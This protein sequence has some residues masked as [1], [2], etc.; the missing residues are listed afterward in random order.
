MPFDP[1]VRL[2][3]FYKEIAT[4][5]KEFIASVTALARNPR[6]RVED[7]SLFL[8]QYDFFNVL[9]EQGYEGK[10]KQF[11]KEWDLQVLQLLKLSDN[12]QAELV[13]QVNVAD[14][15]TVKDLEMKR[16]LR[17]GQDYSDEV[18]TEL[19]KQLLTGADMKTIRDRVLPNI[20]REMPF[21][22]SWFNAMLNTSY[23][24]YN[25]VALQTLT[26]DIPG[27]RYVLRGPTDGHT[28]PACKHAMRISKDNPEGFTLEQINKEAVYGT[29]K[30]KTKEGKV[31]QQI[32]DFKQRGGFN[33][34]HFFEVA[35]E[36]I[37]GG[38][39]VQ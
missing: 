8:T 26:E 10:V 34:R 6:A 28:R 20:Q 30:F 12:M 37:T 14:L 1:N 38:V 36:S 25:A 16:L 5:E 7:F 9:I 15:Q 31:I 33:C 19:L 22:P 24:E 4:L 13:A 39:E 21:Y 35:P 17:R 2:D 3:Q 23:S 32:Y 11:L 29:Y 18:R 27:L